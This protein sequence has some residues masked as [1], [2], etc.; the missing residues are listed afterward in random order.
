MRA[1]RAFPYQLVPGSEQVSSGT[2]SFE[3]SPEEVRHVEVIGN[4]PWESGN[5]ERSLSVRD[6]RSAFDQA[7]GPVAPK[8]T[9]V[10]QHPLRT[11]SNASNSSSVCNLVVSQPV[12]RMASSQTHPPLGICPGCSDQGLKGN[13][14]P[15]CPG[16]MYTRPPLP[17]PAWALREDQLQ[18]AQQ[19]QMIA[20]ALRVA[21]PAPAASE[22]QDSQRLDSRAEI[23]M[24]S[25][26]DPFGPGT[27]RRD[28]LPPPG[29]PPPR[30]RMTSRNCDDAMSASSRASRQA[31][32]DQRVRSLE[33]GMGVL[34]QMQQESMNQMREYFENDSR[35]SSRRTS[36]QTSIVL[37]LIHI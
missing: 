10:N 30:S 28:P 34:M 24:V 25:A 22:P 3:V 29:E 16:F 12:P 2:A 13:E 20:Q 8:V 32:V 5:Q 27:F 11:P 23:P 33:D 35:R 31:E 14:C 7:S 26:F 36:R 15:R 21:A 18:A 9:P 1:H 6:L 19:A 4:P 17:P 37:S